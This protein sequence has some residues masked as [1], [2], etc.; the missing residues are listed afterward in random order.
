MGLFH[1]H[2]TVRNLSIQQALLQQKVRHVLQASHGKTQEDDDHD[3]HDNYHDNYQ[4]CHHPRPVQ[5]RL[6]HWV[7]HCQHPGENRNE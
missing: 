3:H 7:S 2:Q 1:L 4:T 6:Q 5:Q